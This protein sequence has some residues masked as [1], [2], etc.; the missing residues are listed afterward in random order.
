MHHIR[1]TILGAALAC[2]FA[3]TAAFAHAFI[4]HAVPGVGATVSG[5][6]SELTLTFTQS[7][8]PAFASVQITTAGGAPVPAGKATAD[9][10]DPATLHVRLDTLV[11]VYRIALFAGPVIAGVLAARIAAEMR[12][13]VP[14]GGEP[15]PDAVLL[16]RNARGGYEEEGPQAG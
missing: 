9:P 16:V 11:W 12:A 13:R 1:K 8:A 15:P 10:S 14:A 7:L 6:P 5:S 2:S 4:D 3:A